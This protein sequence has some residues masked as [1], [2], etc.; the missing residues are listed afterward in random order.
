M[1]D[2]QGHNPV[3]SWVSG[4]LDLENLGLADAVLSMPQRQDQHCHPV[5][6]RV[7]K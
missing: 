6:A 2:L 7:R 3:L 5:S 1:N 4:A